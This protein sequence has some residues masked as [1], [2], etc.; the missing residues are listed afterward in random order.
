MVMQ[1]LYIVYDFN[2]RSS[3]EERQRPDWRP[4]R[5]R[6]F[7]PRSSYEERRHTFTPSFF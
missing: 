4:K 6:H 1:N 7:N 5:I 3:Y 2:P